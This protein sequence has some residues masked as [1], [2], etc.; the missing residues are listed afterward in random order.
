MTGLRR[1]PSRF[2]FIFIFVTSSGP[3]SCPK[4][5]KDRTRL[6]LQ[7]LD[8]GADLFRSQGIGPLAKRVDNSVGHG[9]G[10][11][12]RYVGRGTTGTGK[13]RGICT[14]HHTR[15]LTRHTRTYTVGLFSISFFIFIYLFI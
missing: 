5:A 4:R 9:Y 10:L 7:T 12:G 14:H 2:L 11:P 15:T 3:R 6:D 1:S 13:G 8:G